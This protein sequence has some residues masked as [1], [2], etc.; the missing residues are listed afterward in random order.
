[1]MTEVAR[2]DTVTGISW[3]TGI[4]TMINGNR[5]VHKWQEKSLLHQPF[6]MFSPRLYRMFSQLEIY[7][8]EHCSVYIIRFCKFEIS[9]SQYV[10][11]FCKVIKLFHKLYPVL[12]SENSIFLFN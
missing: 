6:C 9:I 2:L 10:Q 11:A 7:F 8:E 5:L 1:M 12:F 3:E 4:I